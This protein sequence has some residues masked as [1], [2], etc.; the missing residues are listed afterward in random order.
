MNKID[1]DKVND[2]EFLKILNRKFELWTDFF[3]VYRKTEFFFFIKIEN[4]LKNYMKNRIN[5]DEL[6][7]GD[8]DITSW[9]EDKRKLA[10]YVINIQ[11]LK[12]EYRKLINKI[13]LGKKSIVSRILEQLVKR[14]GREDATSMKFEEV[15]SCLEGETVND[16]SD[17]GVYCYMTWESGEMELFSG[18]EAKE[19]I[20][21]LKSEIPE[22]QVKGMAASRGSVKGRAKVIPLSLNPKEY[23]D[24]VKKGDI[25]VADTTGPEM[26]IAIKKAKAIVTDEGGMMSHAAIVSREFNIPCVV[27]TKCATEVFNDGDLVEVNADKGYAK[28]LE[29]KK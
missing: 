17:R 22:T 9:P 13:I 10:E 29:R 3:D 24:K 8:I 19:K 6:L 16:V 27:G 21:E 26:M 1:V 7:S 15:K 12:F 23:L 20:E 28:I 18:N 5:F 4:E 11:Y 2:R 25:L 14:T